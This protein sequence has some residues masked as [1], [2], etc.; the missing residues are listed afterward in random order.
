MLT[1]LMTTRSP[2]PLGRDLVDGHIFADGRGSAIFRRFNINQD[3]DTVTCIT[4]RISLLIF[5]MKYRNSMKSSE[6]TGFRKRSGKAG[7]PL[8]SPDYAE[9]LKRT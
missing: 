3:I 7:E 5:C 8:T 4:M 6:H 1:M 9:I 2:S